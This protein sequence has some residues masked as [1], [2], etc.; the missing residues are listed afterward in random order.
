MG[1]MALYGEGSTPHVI[2]DN[3]GPT[4]IPVLLVWKMVRSENL[5]HKSI[6]Q[7]PGAPNSI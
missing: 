7:V 2:A 5:S 4:C 1:V 3:A 6:H